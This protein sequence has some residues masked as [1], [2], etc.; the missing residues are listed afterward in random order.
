MHPVAPP[1]QQL[2]AGARRRRVERL[3][4]DAP[5]ARDDGIG[6]KDESARMTCRHGASLGLG[7]T[8]RVP[9]RQL[10]RQRRLVDAGGVDA[11]GGERDLGEKVEAAR[12]GRR[13][14]EACVRQRIGPDG[15][16]L[17]RKVMRPL[18]RS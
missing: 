1:G 5:A 13:Q 3:G 16:Y 17:K 9:R 8:Q 15:G 14:H 18:R 11:V 7:Q 6:A 2:E 4:Q 10:V 12:R